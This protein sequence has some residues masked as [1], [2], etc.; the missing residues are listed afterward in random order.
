[1]LDN[2]VHAED[3]RLYGTSAAHQHSM[4]SQRFDGLAQ[5]PWPSIEYEKIPAT[6]NNYIRP[7]QL[8]T[9]DTQW[10][11]E[12]GDIIHPLAFSKAK[13]SGVPLED[14]D[15]AFVDGNN[16][17][18][19]KTETAVEDAQV[20]RALLLRCWE[21][22]VHA[23][24]NTSCVPV[25][26]GGGGGD[27]AFRL[28]QRQQAAQV[29]STREEARRRSDVETT[30]G[31]KE[32]QEHHEQSVQE[33]VSSR[34]RDRPT[35]I[36]TGVSDQPLELEVEPVG[37]A[38][39]TAKSVNPVRMLPT[40]GTSQNQEEKKQALHS[41]IQNIQGVAGGP[42]FGETAQDY[43]RTAALKKC[44]EWGIKLPKWKF[45]CQNCKL[46]Y[47]TQEELDTHFHGSGNQQGCCW[48][49]IHKK[50]REEL[51]SVMQENVK[52]HTEA[53]LELVMSKAKDKNP[54]QGSG[55]KRARLI[56][57]YDVLQYAQSEYQQAK[58]V[59]GSPK[60]DHPVLE[61][62]EIKAS[63]HRSP[64]VLNQMVLDALRR[65]LVDRYADVPS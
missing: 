35:Q 14:E 2:Q 10:N 13:L 49:V 39:A 55:N 4:R 18:V 29:Q 23:A 32:S 20:P 59:K 17:F 62:T 40:K 8:K 37:T 33:P 60:C 11:L 47:E 63:P 57:W 36:G 61:T 42:R 5:Y 34:T 12:H 41:Y 53:I 43:S 44:Q 48:S 30:Q 56:N 27:Q 6:G 26:G 58:R 51:D 25:G 31:Q 54:P 15:R 7:P 28:L 45:V 52:C 64:L 3:V 38:T 65:R 24:S 50:Q 16:M 21:R 9:D 19:G 46:R 1:M 22:A